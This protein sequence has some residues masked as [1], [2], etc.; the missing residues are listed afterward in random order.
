MQVVDNQVRVFGSRAPMAEIGDWRTVSSVQRLS[1]GTFRAPVWR[2][3]R[4]CQSK[5]KL[6]ALPVEGETVVTAAEGE[7]GGGKRYR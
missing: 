2:N 3:C 1:A 7:A 5:A 4:H 6:S